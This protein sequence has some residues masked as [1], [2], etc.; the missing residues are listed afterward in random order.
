MREIKE[1]TNME[2]YTMFLNWKNQY[3]ANDYTTQSKLQIQCNP[4]QITSG[5]FFFNDTA[6]TEIYTLSLHD[7]LP[8]LVPPALLLSLKIVLAIW[9]LLCLHTNFKIFCSS[10]VKNAIGNLIGIALNL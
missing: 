9:G 4:Y 1:D 7:A 2:R 5:I 10:S 6:T 8:I 3:C